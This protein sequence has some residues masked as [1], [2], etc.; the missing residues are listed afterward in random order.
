[1][2]S[3]TISGIIILCCI[4]MSA[5]FSAT[6]TAFS[7]LN[8]IRIKNM[9]EKGD[10]K[11]ALVLELSEHYDSLLSTILIGNNIVNIGS[12]SLAAVLFVKLL[13]E[14]AGASVST[15]A[16]T[17][18][19]LIFGEISPKSIAKESP[20]Q[21]ARFSAPFLKL[22]M[23][24]LTPLNFI[25][26]QWKKLLTRFFKTSSDD[27]I[28]EEELLTIVE[29]AESVGGIGKDEGTL[30]KSALSFCDLTAADVLTPRVEVVGIP[31]EATVEETARIFDQTGYSRLPV[32]EGDMDHIFGILYHKDF[33]NNRK[34][35][36]ASI[37]D[38]VRP[39]LFVSRSRKIDGL[40]RE[41]QEKKLHIGVVMDEYG[42]T[43]GI[44]TLEDI[45]EELVGEIWDEHDQVVCEIE[46]TGA[47][48][49][50][51]S[52]RAHVEKLFLSLGISKS[53][54][55]EA[56]TVSGW[57]MEQIGCIPSVGDNFLY[58]GWNLE[59]LAMVGKR[60]DKI[61]AY[62]VET[63]ARKTM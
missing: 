45:L 15:I 33:Y 14:E 22:L 13:G 10:R 37:R 26:R 7:S 27:G 44:V 1:M 55:T 61:R 25:F 28:T 42:G 39:V 12:A 21:F 4:V 18:V 23:K 32:Y 56:R 57:V 36:E 38:G 3:N 46:E 52:G 20:E 49:Y 47:G 63:N 2:G 51:V 31:A 9:A 24:L 40:M 5:Y 54:E 62:K 48:E 35:M 58:A 43:A 59:V 34:Q 29:E 11:A 8:R 60:I 17:V 30:L 6:E 50:D 53:P 16:T 41:L 19:V